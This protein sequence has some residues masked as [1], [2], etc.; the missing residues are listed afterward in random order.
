MYQKPIL[1]CVCGAVV[2]Y[3]IS[4]PVVTLNNHPRCHHAS[5]L[6]QRKL[7]KRVDRG[8]IKIHPLKK[9]LSLSEYSGLRALRHTQK[10]E[11]E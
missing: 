10:G 1:I 8:Q 3:I 11:S 9:A 4:F 2:E 6:Q 7:Y 5:L